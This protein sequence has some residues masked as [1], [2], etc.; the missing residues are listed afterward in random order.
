MSLREIIKFTLSNFN[1]NLYSNFQFE[2]LSFLDK[3]GYVD[4]ICIN[5]MEKE[6]IKCAKSLR[7]QQN[8]VQELKLKTMFV[9]QLLT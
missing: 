4:M 7:Q 2:N 8:L 5:K 9:D 1:F 6:L 3:H